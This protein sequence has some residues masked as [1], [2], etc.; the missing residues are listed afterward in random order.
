MQPPPCVAGAGFPRLLP[1][2]ERFEGAFALGYCLGREWRPCIYKSLPGA[3]TVEISRRYL[4]RQHEDPDMH[5]A[6]GLTAMLMETAHPKTRLGSGT[7]TAGVAI[8]AAT[9]ISTIF[10]ALDRSG[11]G[12]TPAEILAGIA[13]LTALKEV[14]HGVAIA[15]VCAYAFGYASLARRLGL[16]RPQVLAGL[17]VYLIGCVAMIAATLLD[18]FITPHIAVDAMGAAPE[19]VQFAYDLVHYLGVMLNDFAKLGWTLQAVGALAWSLLLMREKGF[20]RA[21]GMIGVLS[22]VLVGVAV[23]ASATNMSMAS[24]LGVLLAQLIWNLAAAA[25]LFR[26]QAASMAAHS[27]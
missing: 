25:F 20:D 19:R 14:V 2:I 3:E 10:V 21:I 17:A 5:G 6:Q 27:A 12:S 15:S 7:R 8:A 16:H 24:L 22:S 23:L 1:A 13:G 9:I 11:G 26:S 4:A 18:G